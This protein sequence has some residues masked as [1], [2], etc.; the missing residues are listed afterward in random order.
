MKSSRD[1]AKPLEEIAL[2]IADTR[3]MRRS[4]KDASVLS[5]AEYLGFL[6]RASARVEPSRRTSAGWAA[7]N[8]PDAGPGQVK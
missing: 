8:L 6:T 7:F 3:A 2:T 5:T 1:P 4:A